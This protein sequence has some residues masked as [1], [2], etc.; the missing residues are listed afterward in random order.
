MRKATC[1]NRQ[2]AFLLLPNE[3]DLQWDGIH[4]IIQLRTESETGTFQE[5]HPPD[6]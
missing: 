5:A 6:T 3:G 1:V 2:V 4:N